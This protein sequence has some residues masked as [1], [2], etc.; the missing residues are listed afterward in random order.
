MDDDIESL[1]KLIRR[2]HL[3]DGYPVKLQSDVR[4]FIVTSNCHAAWVAEAC[5][6]LVG[7]VSLHTVWSDA[8][9]ALA[10]GVLGCQRDQLGA[11]SRL[12]VAP[13]SRGGGIGQALLD[14]AAKAARA[15]S[16]HPVLDVATSYGPAIRLYEAANWE[17]L[18]TVWLEMP[19]GEPIAEHVYA[20]PAS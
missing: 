2:V 5:G 4:S 10:C 17:R 14:A 1:C 3:R 20:A 15:R 13:E 11:V 19:D 8:V 7:H 9:A 16:L 18:G 6:S 12:F